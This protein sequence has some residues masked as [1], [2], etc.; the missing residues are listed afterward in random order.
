MEMLASLAVEAGGPRSL[1]GDT[2]ARARSQVTSQKRTLYLGLDQFA[3][4][5]GRHAL[6]K[7]TIVVILD[8]EVYDLPARDHLQPKHQVVSSKSERLVDQKVQKTK[9]LVAQKVILVAG[10]L[11]VVSDENYYFKHG[12]YAI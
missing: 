6:R 10:L 12:R 4:L 11:L 1:V 7:V 3:G 8:R 5:R 9:I 2:W